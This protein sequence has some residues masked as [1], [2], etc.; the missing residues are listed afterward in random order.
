MNHFAYPV[1]S[2]RSYDAEQSPGAGDYLNGYDGS[3]QAAWPSGASDEHAEEEEAYDEEGGGGAKW[4]DPEL[5]NALKSCRLIEFGIT[6]NGEKVKVMMFFATPTTDSTT[7][8]RG[9][10]TLPI[11]GDNPVP[12]GFMFSDMSDGSAMKPI[13]SR[14][15]NMTLAEDMKGSHPTGS[16]QVSI[17]CVRI[18]NVMDTRPR[19][20]RRPVGMTITGI[21]ARTAATTGVSWDPGAK[22][23]ATVMHR[24]AASDV[25]NVDTSTAPLVTVFHG[26]CHATQYNSEY[27]MWGE[28]V[29]DGCYRFSIASFAAVYLVYNLVDFMHQY[30]SKTHTLPPGID[31]GLLDRLTADHRAWV[32]KKRQNANIYHP[33]AD[34]SDDYVGR[35]LET[36]AH[37]APQG[38]AWKV[39]QQYP[40]FHVPAAFIQQIVAPEYNA[41]SAQLVLSNPSAIAVRA[42][43]NNDED[44]ER[45]K[46]HNGT[47]CV[48]V[49]ATVFVPKMRFVIVNQTQRNSLMSK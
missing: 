43:Y 24:Q 28:R 26:T 41:V 39:E 34:L 3:K 48:D 31:E 13:L 21:D 32:G 23:H 35:T 11:N 37:G 17:P 33:E 12:M 14:I 38:K 5:K 10:L 16:K 36:L 25:Y 9:M 6:Q 7:K 8:R 22:Y 2:H 18:L 30:R 44:A 19:E 46:T 1:T 40:R 4:S 15:D 20:D 45:D 27:G 47:I 29:T 42:H 49:E